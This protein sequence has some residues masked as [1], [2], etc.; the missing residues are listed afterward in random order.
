MKMICL[1]GGSG[2]GKSTVEKTLENFGFK[3]S[4]SYTTR[5]PRMRNGKLEQD[6]NE[7]RF[8]SREKF[9]AL[10]DRGIIIEHEYYDGN[11]YG[12]P[13]PIGATRYVAT[14]CLGGF[15]ALKKKYG[16]QVIGVYLECPYEIALR[17]AGLRDKTDEIALRRLEEDKKLIAKMSEC[18]DLVVDATNDIGYTVAE[19]LKKVRE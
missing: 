14:V 5:E 1:M 18:A 19:I 9:L 4:I 17:R 13:V 16:D 2:S 6:G 7:Y 12:T 10:V 3:R 8:V 15:Q 11:Y